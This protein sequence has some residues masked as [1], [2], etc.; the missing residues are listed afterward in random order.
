VRKFIY[1]FLTV[2]LLLSFSDAGKD[3]KKFDYPLQEVPYFKVKING[4]LWKMKIDS[5]IKNTV[6]DNL[7]KISSSGKMDNFSIAAGI[8]KGDFSSNEASDSDVY[9]TL[10]GACYS[11]KLH[12]D[13]VLEH[14][15]DSLINII[16]KVQEPDGY[17]YTIRYF[18]PLGNKCIGGRWANLSHSHELYDMGHMI[19]AAVAHYEATGK[20]NFLDMAIKTAD[21]ISYTFGAERLR[22]IPGHQ[23]IELALAKL[24][25]VTGKKE[26][27]DVAKFFIDER[28]HYNN[29]RTQYIFRNNLTY[30]LDHKPVLEQEE[31]TGHAVRAVY[32]YAGMVDIGAVT[33]NQQYVEASNRLWEN[34]TGKKIY[35]TGGVGASATK[36]EA[37]DEAYM[38]PNL[39]A[40][41]ETC[42]AV[43]NMLWNFRLGKFY[44]DAKYFD[45]LERTLYNAY[46][47]STSVHG[48]GYLYTNPLSDKGLTDRSDW[49]DPPCC[50]TN[51]CRT[52]TSIGG[53]MY[54][55]DADNL[56][57]N[58]FMK[59]ESKID[60]GER[61]ITLKQ[62]TEY[63]WDGQIK[64]KL[65][66]DKPSMFSI[67]IR[68][69]GWAREEA[70]PLGLYKYAN[71]VNKGILINVNGKEQKVILELGYAVIK[72]NWQANDEISL[73]LPMEIRRVVSDEKVKDDVGRVA[74][75]RGPIVYC[76][77]WVDNNGRTS[78]IILPDESKLSSKYV[79]NLIGGITIIE[80]KVKIIDN[81]G[82]VK[83]AYFKAIPYFAWLNR[84]KGE[85]D[86]WLQRNNAIL[87]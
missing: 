19:E 68:V 52:T 34:A 82:K 73:V 10:Q 50:P 81:A 75:E 37:F 4:G 71:K 69:P 46:L 42:G 8:K 86:I 64:F 49:F 55:T 70:I 85:M 60:F 61:S 9:K 23:E 54:L 5:C 76:A 77:E 21:M 30:Y 66:L 59:S 13:P 22:L 26:Y 87:N 63:P 17:I 24:Y 40:Y 41:A 18:K 67:R 3:E 27:I 80:G 56:Y 78:N 12:P 7:F 62:E 57:I 44:K 28:G 15:V 33:G 45:V 43:G 11:L 48:T 14:Y 47:P 36:G 31:A 84:G 32:M 6:W 58:L 39:K 38:L 20:R 65:G 25:K 2:F 16:A 83:P 79:S 35:L 74:L 51:I 1:L 72:R 29:G 53:Y